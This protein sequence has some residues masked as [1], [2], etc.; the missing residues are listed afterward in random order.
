MGAIARR[1]TE[2]GIPT[3]TGKRRWD[4]S[5]IWAMLRNPAYCG[6]ACYG[7]TGTGPRRKLTR[8]SRGPGKFP[9]RQVQGI[10]R[11]RE[12]WIESPVPALVSEEQFTQAREE[13][14][15]NRRHARRRTKEPTLLHGMLVC[16]QCGYAYYRC[17]TRTTKRKLYYYRCLGSDG[18]RYEEGARCASRPLRQD[19]MDRLVWAELVRLLEEPTLLEAELERRLEAGREADPQR[20]RVEEL[21][22]ERARLERASERLLTAYQEELISLDELRRRIPPMRDRKR[23]LEAELEA[24][25][26]A[27]ADR[28]QYPQIAETLASLRERLRAG[29]RTLEVVDR[30]KVLRFLVK[31]VLVGDGEITICH[32][33]PVPE[34]GGS[35]QRSSG[36]NS[37]PHGPESPS[38]LLRWGSL[39]A[40]IRQPRVTLLSQAIVGLSSGLLNA[41]L[42]CRRKRG[43]SRPTKP[44]GQR[45]ATKCWGQ[46]SSVKNST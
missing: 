19:R 42:K 7:K 37:P 22:T 46:A 27:A 21:R 3:R 28:E 33:I 16:R 26:T 40:R 20:C 18:W 13:L 39:L 9:S 14:E 4:R 25:E 32:S 29:A 38:Y 44:S 43:H 23:E 34:A 1:L 30:Q 36:S 10:E 41:K 12:E 15:W 11:P 17:S 5:V 45:Q 8:R 2:R 31:E 6:R 24:I 35:P